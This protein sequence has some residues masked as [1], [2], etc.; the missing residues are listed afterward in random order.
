MLVT[1]CGCADQ[2]L[3]SPPYKVNARPHAGVKHNS[4]PQC[5]VARKYVCEYRQS[6]VARSTLLA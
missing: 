4:V 6:A 2:V 1:A 3:V 5:M